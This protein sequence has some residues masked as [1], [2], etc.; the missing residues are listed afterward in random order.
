MT[1][2]DAPAGRL[3]ASS[4]DAH[5]HV[6]TGPVGAVPGAAYTPFEAPVEQFLAHLDRLGLQRGVLVTPSVYGPNNAVLLDALRTAPDRLRGVAVL[7][8]RDEDDV[9]AELDAA[10]VR[11]CRAQDS[12]L[13][14]DHLRGLLALQDRVRGFGWH[15]EVWTH[16]WAHR[17]LLRTAAGR[18][19]LLLDHLG[20]LP[21]PPPGEQDPAVPLLRDLLNAGDVWVTLSGGYRLLPGARETDAA[22]ALRRR[23]DAVLTAAPDRVVWGTDW[24]YVNPPGP[25]PTPAD[26]RAVLDNWLPDPGIRHRVLVDNP[27]VLYQWA[28]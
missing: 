24:P 11:A 12:L 1:T 9:L 14:G 17:D 8:A 25:A 13:R 6:M 27:A 28:T 16:P 19:R 26:H 20:L 10:G 5:A 2:D 4:T 7:N 15:V 21:A 18:G 23:V 22:S 3:P